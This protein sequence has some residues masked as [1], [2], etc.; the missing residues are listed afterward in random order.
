M[1]P[2]GGLFGPYAVEETIGSGAMG[3]VYRA[4]HTVTQQAVALKALRTQAPG[5]LT[6]F[7]RE[8]HVLAGLRHPNI[9]RILDQGFTQGV[10]W[11]AMELIEGT[12]LQAR[13]R[14]R[15]DG[16]DSAREQDDSEAPG[17]LPDVS[18]VASRA[19]ADPSRPSV[20]IRLPTDE[21]IRWAIPVCRGLAFLHGCGVVHRDLKPANILI[22]RDGTPVLVDF[23]LVLPFGGTGRE[24]LELAEAGSG[25]LAYM[26]PEQRF[27]RFVDARADLFSLGCIMYEAL[28]G[29]L[30]FGPGGVRELSPEPRAPSAFVTGI[31]D[32]L[33][34]L[35]MRLLARSPHDR[36]GYADDVAAMLLALEGA[37]ARPLSEQRTTYLYRS[38]FVGRR[39]TFAKL[40][41]AID[42]ALRG[43]GG[44]V[45]VTAASGA[46]KTRL[47]LE[48]A[49]LASEKGMAVITGECLPSGTAEGGDRALSAPLHPLRRLLT[50]VADFCRAA[51]SAT[52]KKL[53]GGRAGLLVPYERLLGDLAQQL[54]ETEPPP[55]PPDAARARVLNTLAALV[56]DFA[57]VRPLLFVIDDLQW[58][59]ELSLDL[60]SSL[61]GRGCATAPFLLW[62]TCR[63]EEMTPRLERLF[64]AP[65][66]VHTEL[67]RLGKQEVGQMVGGMLA[68]RAPPPELVDFLYF[69][70]G[71]NPFLLSEYL[72]TAIA[73]GRLERNARGRWVLNDRRLQSVTVPTAI[74]ALIRRRLDGLDAKAKRIVGAAAVLGRGFDTE[75]LA[76][77]VDLDIADVLDAYGTLRQ[78]QIFE[79]DPSGILRFVHDQL[80]DTAYLTLGEDERAQLHGRAAAAIEE[81]YSG[82]ELE[83]YLAALGFH[84]AKAGAASRAAGY[85]E[86]AADLARRTYANGD[87]VKLYRLAIAQIDAASGSPA[88]RSLARAALQEA[89]G[90]I[91]HMTGDARG[92]R[93]A[94]EAALADSPEEPSVARGRRLRKGARTWERQHQHARALQEFAR[95]EVQLGDEGLAQE[96]A[97]EWWHEWVQVQVDKTW[98]LYWLARVDELSELVERVRPVVERHGSASQRAQFY[99]ALVHTAL[100]RERYA[101]LEQAVEYA[102]KSLAAAEQ[103]DDPREL[104]LARF[105][106]GFPLLFARE[107]RESEPLFLDAIAAANR[108][109]DA[110]LQARFL[111]YYAV[112]HRRA[113]RVQESR[114]VAERA[115]SIAEQGG[116][117]DYVGVAHACLAWAAWKDGHRGELE[118]HAS[119]CLGAWAQLLPEYDYPLH[120]LVR[121]PLAAQLAADGELEKAVEHWKALLVPTQHLL[122]PPLQSAIEQAIQSCPARTEP[123]ALSSATNVVRLATE[124]GYL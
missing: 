61:T 18:L 24:V 119:I 66:S 45:F 90:D 62:G 89:I 38:E 91:L 12:S 33:E 70:S 72:R 94:F 5:M 10:P 55:L 25:T 117:L 39:E 71:G 124:L 115:A 63:I 123:A 2:A 31:P 51:D 60:L 11:L 3:V 56:L 76:R 58:A 95:A 23:G 93:E 26:A 59:D 79:D 107:L 88:E 9:V 46:G 97:D 14:P 105:F 101:H 54:G 75:L 20:A 41:Q 77:T 103:C 98:D 37:E 78:R 82:P 109:G 57:R 65:G 85:F 8:V 48:A 120:W 104:A 27:G 112:L 43:R 108:I 42:D 81:R 6:S 99:Q 32:S 19:S 64:H 53:L 111:A 69:E 67:D 21:M 13:L 87:A 102:R 50:G 74:A 121:M 34:T 16:S 110:T 84:L 49:T 30:P 4:R 122:P 96:H 35:T 15:R 92:A 100:R 40:A 36:I 73:E 118:H 116:M 17:T 86:R 80:R 114:S 22:R 1:A 83:P 106:L 7:R 68:L 52:A 29:V 28:T 44:R 113:G 47:V